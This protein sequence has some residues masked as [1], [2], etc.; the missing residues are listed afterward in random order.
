MLQFGAVL[1]D[2]AKKHK[3]TQAD[4]AKMS[5]LD[6][7]HLSRIVHGE[8]GT[9]PDA[10]K[11]ILALFRDREDRSLIISALVRDQLTQLDIPQTEMA[12]SLAPSAD[13]IADIADPEVHRI[14]FQFAQAIAH[15]DDDLRQLI[16]LTAKARFGDQAIL[17][18]AEEAPTARAHRRD[19]ASRALALPSKPTPSKYSRRRS[20]AGRVDK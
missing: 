20:A 18:V 4:I 10:A 19:A 1:L 2:V 11:K 14:L 3:W 16:R 8:I 13:P 7:G 15:G 6:Q 9:T 12:V 17:E 5:K